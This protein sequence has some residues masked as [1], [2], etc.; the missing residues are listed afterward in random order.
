MFEGIVGISWIPGSL[1]TSRSGAS[2]WK[3]KLTAVWPVTSDTDF[4]LR[5]EAPGDKSIDVFGRIALAADDLKPIGFELD[6]DR[7]PQHLLGYIVT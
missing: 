2:G 3:S 4:Q 1:L 7:N 5:S 6:A